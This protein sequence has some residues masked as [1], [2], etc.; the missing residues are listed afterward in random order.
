MLISISYVVK[1]Y[2]LTESTTDDLKNPWDLKTLQF[3]DVMLKEIRR[4]MANK[5]K[6]KSHFEEV[7]KEFI[8]VLEYCN[9]EEKAKSEH[10]RFHSKLF[11]ALEEIG[12]GHLINVGD[13]ISDDTL[14]LE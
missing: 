1:Y 3:S 4:V 2:Y 10:R 8:P 11:D 13:D 7:V 9:S 5:K 6:V 12:R 14:L